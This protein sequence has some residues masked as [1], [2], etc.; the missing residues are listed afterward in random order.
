[1]P[2]YATDKQNNS[3]VLKAYN[4]GDENAICA[5]FERVFGKPMGKTESLRHWRWEFLEN[6]ADGLFVQ[7]AWDGDKLVGQYTASPVQMYANGINFTAALSHDTMTDP[8]YGGLGIFRAAAETLY[9]QQTDAGQGFIYGFPN[10]NSIHGFIKYLQW[11]QIMPAPVHIRP[12]SIFKNSF[13][14][15]LHT[16]NDTSSV[17]ES[18]LQNTASLFLDK[19]G[20]H[21]MRVEKEFGDWADELWMRCR[22]QHRLW[23]VR[24][25]DYLNWRYVTKPENKYHIVSI[26]QGDQPVGYVVIARSD[27]KFGDTLFIMDFLVDLNFECAADL[28][29]RYVINVAKKNKC[30]F[31][32]ILLTLGSKYLNIFRKKIFLPLPKFL[33]PQPLYFGA[34]CFDPKMRQLINDPKAWHISWGDNDVI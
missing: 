29:V 18:N 2:E 28:L 3:F 1:M 25:K 13:N 17:G 6:P 4:P 24:N 8:K 19:S 31:V 20:K 15:I 30:A 11:Q 21:R 7:L 26:W 9:R 12:V 27:M 33:F 32:S 14:K 23:V 34:R 22:N 5:L 10:R 16:E